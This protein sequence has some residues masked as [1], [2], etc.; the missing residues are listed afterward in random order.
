MWEV[1]GSVADQVGGS[2]VS[3]VSQQ[4]AARGSSDRAGSAHALLLLILR[5]LRVLL[6][7][8]VAAFRGALLVVLLWVQEGG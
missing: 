5:L 8:R 3:K 4:R 1:E 7:L 6:L 2:T